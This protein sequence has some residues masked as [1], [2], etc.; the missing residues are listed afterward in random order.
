M[1]T[2]SFDEICIIATGQL[3]LRLSIT[4]SYLCPPLQ[5]GADIEGYRCSE[6][7]GDRHPRNR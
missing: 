3:K 4:P 5:W 7:P 2:V 1:S 6:R